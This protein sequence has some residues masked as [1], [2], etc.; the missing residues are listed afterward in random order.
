M[1]FTYNWANNEQLINLAISQSPTGDVCLLPTSTYVKIT[2]VVNLVVN[3]T[4]VDA[5]DSAACPPPAK[6]VVLNP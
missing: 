6:P 4:T 3:E 2:R 1:R 5:G